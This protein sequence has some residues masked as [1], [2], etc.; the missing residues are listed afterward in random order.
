MNFLNILSDIEQVDPEIYDRL[1]SRRRVFKHF[2]LAGKAVTAAV[3][4]G[5]P[6]HASFGARCEPAPA[7]GADTDSVLQELLGTGAI[8]PE[9]LG[10]QGLTL[11]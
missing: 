3:L 1:D 10:G 7:L 5:L 4:P 6:W 8:D 2:G 9:M 11:S